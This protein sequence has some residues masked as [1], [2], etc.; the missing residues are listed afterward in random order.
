MPKVMSRLRLPAVARSLKGQIRGFITAFSIEV[1]RRPELHHDR[2][3]G[4]AVPSFFGEVGHAHADEG[5]TLA[6]YNHVVLI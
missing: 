4:S 1:V 6:P 2:R 5:H 3:L